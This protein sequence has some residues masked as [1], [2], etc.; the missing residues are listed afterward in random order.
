MRPIDLRRLRAAAKRGRQLL[1]SLPND[2]GADK[3]FLETEQLLRDLFGQTHLWAN[4]AQ[5][6]RGNVIGEPGESLQSVHQKFVR[7]R[8]RY[9]VEAVEAALVLP[10]A[11][12]RM[13]LYL[14][15]HS[16]RPSD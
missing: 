4:F 2:A 1:V 6:Y 11:A 5:G 13:D 3:W 8:V 16:L 14:A 15:T 12:L 10:S 7:N 9:W